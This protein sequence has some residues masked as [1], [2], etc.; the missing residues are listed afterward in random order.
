VRHYLSTVAVLFVVTVGG[1]HPKPPPAGIPNFAIVDVAS[2]VYRGGQPP[3]PEAWAELKELGVERIIKL[4][5]E[6]E[7]SDAA[8]VALGLKVVYLPIS[9]MDQL[10]GSPQHA[11]L[12]QAVAEM[13][14]G[15]CF[16][17]CGGDARSKPDS[18]AARMGTQGGQDRTGLA[19]AC[20]RVWGQHWTKADAEKEMLARGFHPGL[21]GLARFWREQVN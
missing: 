12:D 17:H 16:V 4:N 11:T 10:I 2:K 6:S 13:R 18:V 8:G 1:D 5:Q 19:V 14:L 3:T 20:F 21:P 9:V 15:K 7:G